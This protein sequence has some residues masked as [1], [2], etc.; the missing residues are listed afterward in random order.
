MVGE[1]EEEEEDDDDDDE[2]PGESGSSTRA[3][4]VESKLGPATLQDPPPPEKSETHARLSPCA[5][6]PPTEPVDRPASPSVA[7]PQH[8][9]IQ[10]AGAGDRTVAAVATP[11][12]P[13]PPPLAQLSPAPAPALE[14]EEE[15]E[16]WEIRKIVAKRRAGEDD[17]FLVCWTNSW[18]RRSELGNAQRLLKEFEVRRRARGGRKPSKMGSRR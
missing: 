15:E 14:E 12:C 18:L 11:R 2:R 5:P 7:L 3:T 4:R 16:E 6:Q 8:L 1:E 17:E 10:D 13:S 9:D